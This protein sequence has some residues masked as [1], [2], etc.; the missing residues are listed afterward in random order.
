MIDVIVR[1]FNTAYPHPHC[2]L[3][4]LAV[5]RRCGSE[6]GLCWAGVG[7]LLKDTGLSRSGF[8]RARKL[9]EEHSV[10]GVPAPLLKRWT[11]PGR[12]NG[13]RRSDLMALRFPD[14]T[15]PALALELPAAEI[16]SG[17]L[18]LW[19][20]VDLEAGQFE[21]PEDP[22]SHPGTGSLVDHRSHPGILL[23]GESEAKSQIATHLVSNSDTEESL[24]ETID[25]LPVRA[26]E[27]PVS[28][29]GR[30]DP[31]KAAAYLWH[32]APGKSRERSSLPDTM[33]ALSLAIKEGKVG[34]QHPGDWFSV[35]AKAL[36]LYAASPGAVRE[37]GRYCVAL[38]RLLG[39][40]KFWGEWF[41]R[42][43]ASAAKEGVGVLDPMKPDLRFAR[44]YMQGWTRSK[45]WP[46]AQGP[47]P[48]EPGCVVPPEV[49][50]EFGMSLADQEPEARR[51][52]A[53]WIENGNWRHAW[54]PQPGQ[55]GCLVPSAL[56]DAM[57]AEAAA[58]AA[59][60]PD[61]E[62][63]PDLLDDDDAALF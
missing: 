53:G 2:K 26:P 18:S 14:V 6:T 55:P 48:L 29:D 8:Y 34:K 32:L 59:P 51:R 28:D 5:A 16:E 39:M 17:Q 42:G 1:V 46:G 60:E 35:V 12:A 15:L 11:R 62:P 31:E 25:S 24:E 36:E 56:V 43:K 63:G 57:R 30:F 40:E 49:L 44:I 10:G 22:E 13:R 41:V 54:G 3:L 7:T 27:W 38:H 33:A 50:A 45:F 19:D 58:V 61:P 47:T 52:V 37:D 20:V 9:M 4:A 21:E 23:S